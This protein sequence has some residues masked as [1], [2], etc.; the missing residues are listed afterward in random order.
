MPT[1]A[2]TMKSV[3]AGPN[4]QQL[5]GASAGHIDYNCIPLGGVQASRGAF[6]WEVIRMIPK[7]IGVTIITV[8]AASILFGGIHSAI[9]VIEATDAAAEPSSGEFVPR[10]APDDEQDPALAALRYVCP[11]H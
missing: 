1:F 8:F 2:G 4:R 6:R 5:K 10:L 7:I 9:L 11:F 3:D